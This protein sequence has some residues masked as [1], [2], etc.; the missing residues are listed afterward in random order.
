MTQI[1]SH[2]LDCTK[3]GH[4]QDNVIWTSLNVSLDPNL[5]EKL[6]NGEINVLVC[7]KCGNRALISV[8]LLYHDMKRKYCVQYYPI[9]VIE[10]AE[11][12]KRFTKDGK[13]NIDGLSKAMGE[14]GH[15][16]VEPH[17]VFDLN[18]MIQYIKFR[19]KL[20]DLHKEL[21]S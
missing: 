17:I 1:K 4:I 21:V 18:E 14:I 5:R 11:F 20:H 12:F 16:M 9:R 13:L 7:Q 3:C 19:D 10:D 15:Y 6:F 2:K 8:A